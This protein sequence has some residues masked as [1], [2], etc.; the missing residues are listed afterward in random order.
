MTSGVALREGFSLARRARAA[1]WLLFLV[2]LALA[3][4]AAVPIYRGVLRSTGHSWMGQ[5]M[6]TGFQVEWLTDFSVNSP[7]SLDRYAEFM[8]LIG[9]LAI[10]INSILAGGV[11]SRFR[12]PE[13]PFA[14]GGFFRDT[15]RYFWRLLRLMLIGLVFYWI[16]F[17]VFNQWLG[18]WIDVRMYDWQDDRVVFA[19]RSG[20]WLALFA[21]LGFINLVVDYA[22]LKLVLEDGSSAAG[23]FLSSLGFALS[24]LRR[25]VTIYVVPIAASVALLGIY[26]WIVPW[27]LVNAVV[28]DTGIA[29]YQE[30]LAV[31]L[32][33][34]GQQLVMFGRYWF[35]VAGWASAWSFYSASRT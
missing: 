32:L 21:A 17:R 30:P 28:A 14:L 19:V 12:F 20:L 22:R 1:V 26:W 3:A 24:R 16:A 6:L 9:L 8:A 13:A 18:Q 10:P 5:K 33:F 15:G 29:Q 2:N 7:G 35:R 11:L 34:I 25:T 27:S 23:A 31:A 4:V